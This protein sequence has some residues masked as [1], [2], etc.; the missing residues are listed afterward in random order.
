[1]CFDFIL[2][3]ETL[4]DVDTSML[5]IGL[6]IRPFLCLPQR[7]PTVLRCGIHGWSVDRFNIIEHNELLWIVRS[8]RRR[9]LFVMP[10]KSW[11]D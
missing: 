1:M 2:P 9:R 4:F 6:S 7:S 5:E 10:D 8:P 11:V 3:K